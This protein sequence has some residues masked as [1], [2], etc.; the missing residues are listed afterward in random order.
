ML[1]FSVNGNWN[2]AQ[3]QTEETVEHFF[4]KM[5]QQLSEKYR[6]I[7]SLYFLENTGKAD[8]VTGNPVLLFGKPS[9]T[10][11]LLGLTFEI[12]PKSFFQV[13]TLGA[14]LL[15][16][17]AIESLQSK[18]GILLDLYAGTG[19]IGI[20]ISKHFEK[21]Y[22]VELVTDASRDGEKNAERNGVNNIEF[23]NAKVEDFVAKI[24]SEYMIDR[25][26]LAIVIDPPRDGMH[27]S[28]LPSLLSFGAREI[29][30]VSCNPATLARDLEILIGKNRDEETE[31]LPQYRIT[32]VTPVDMFPHTHHVENVALLEL[33]KD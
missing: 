30:Y 4:T 32:D 23:I 24:G 25:S 29:V 33:R 20:L 11:E 3:V 5:V 28:T 2:D 6:N 14:E 31:T 22:S 18:N 19:T 12:Q 10:E 15:Y 1:I 26:K 13:N 21:V 9:I 7:A 17:R 8:I 16:T 27:P